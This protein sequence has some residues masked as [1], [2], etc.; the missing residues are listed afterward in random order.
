[1]EKKIKLTMDSSKDIHIF[2]NDTEKYIIN[3]TSRQISAQLIF[4]ILEYSAGDRYEVISENVEGKDPEV[5]KFFVDLLEDITNK[6]QDIKLDDG[7]L[8]N[9][10]A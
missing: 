8:E 1:M 9:D 3:N 7:I 6:I 4:D 5:L 2:V 10:D